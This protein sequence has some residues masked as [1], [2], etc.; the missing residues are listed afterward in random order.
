MAKERL[1]ALE[2]RPI[3][4]GPAKKPAK[5]KVFIVANPAPLA[6]PG[7]RAA[8]PYK[9][10]APH[11]TPA[12]TKPKPK[13]AVVVWGTATANKIPNAAIIPPVTSTFRLPY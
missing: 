5:L 3:N 13:M 1:Y 8:L 10:G 4:A 11:D 2:M 12:P 7:T 6:M 9:I